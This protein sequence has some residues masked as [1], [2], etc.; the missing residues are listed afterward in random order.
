MLL[1]M[2]VA[3]LELFPCGFP[4]NTI[5][6]MLHRFNRL[7]QKTWWTSMKGGCG[8]GT[9]FSCDGSFAS[10]TSLDSKYYS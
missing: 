1:K 8:P 2:L 10:E 9:K 6:K 3:E 7:T 5:Q 4:L